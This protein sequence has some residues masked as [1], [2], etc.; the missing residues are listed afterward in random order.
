MVVENIIHNYRNPIITSL[1]T[2]V[3]Q[4][5]S[6]PCKSILKQLYDKSPCTIQVPF[7]AVTVKGSD[8]LNPW[9]FLQRALDMLAFECLDS[10]CL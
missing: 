4:H 2:K 7:P 9:G 10:P 3:V 1:E 5:V 6:F 8:D